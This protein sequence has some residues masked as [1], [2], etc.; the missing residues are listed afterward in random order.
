MADK[1]RPV[2]LHRSDQTS[3]IGTMECSERVLHASETFQTSRKHR[4]AQ[5]PD[6]KNPWRN[7][8]PGVRLYLDESKPVTAQELLAR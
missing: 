7:H 5:S 8:P 2:V 4:T 6:M 3:R 1:P